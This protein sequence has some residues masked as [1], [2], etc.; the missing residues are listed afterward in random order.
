MPHSKASQVSAGTNP[1]EPP[2]EDFSGVRFFSG[3][4]AVNLWAGHMTPLNEDLLTG[5]DAI[6]EFLGW[7]VRRVYHASKQKHLPIGRA[8][9][10]LIARKSELDRAL[11]GA[12]T[13]GAQRGG[14]HE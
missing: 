4:G 10:L 3:I 9:S 12:P 8:G 11:S 6:A 1:G 2:I 13:N 5:A 14:D 7:N